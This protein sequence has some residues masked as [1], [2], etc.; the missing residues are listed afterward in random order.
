MSTMDHN[1]SLAPDVCNAFKVGDTKVS[2]VTTIVARA[3]EKQMQF[4]QGV[5]AEI[6]TRLDVKLDEV[7]CLLQK[8]ISWRN[9]SWRMNPS[10][11]DRNTASFSGELLG[12]TDEGHSVKLHMSRDL[13]YEGAE[14]FADNKQ[15]ASSSGEAMPSINKQGTAP[16]DAPHTCRWCRQSYNTTQSAPS[17]NHGIAYGA[18]RCT[19]HCMTLTG[20]G[21]IQT[22]FC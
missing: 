6:S 9:R 14:Y 22:E 11:V 5:A 17:A 8:E 13:S 19:Y 16:Q 3:V 15:S 7:E 18:T 2:A 20:V 12:D 1:E 10:T 21:T 4:V